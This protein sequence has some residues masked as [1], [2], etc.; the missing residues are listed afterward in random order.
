LCFALQAAGQTHVHV[1]VFVGIDPGLTFHRGF[2]DGARFH[3]GV[4]LIAGA[5]EEAG[6]DEHHTLGGAA[7]ALCEV[8]GGAAL[9]VH[10]ADLNGVAC[11][12]KQVF[13]GAEQMTVM[14]T[15]SGPCI[16]GLTMYMEP[17]REFLAAF[18]SE[19]MK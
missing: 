15:S 3:A 13:D 18:A 7:D 19:V 8:Y 4:N 17:A 6:V 14:L 11:K 1:P 2:G 12:A 16:L 5:V 10:N 9:L